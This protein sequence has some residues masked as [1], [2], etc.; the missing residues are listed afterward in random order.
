MTVE[1]EVKWIFHEEGS[2]WW[3]DIYRAGAN[4][5][6]DFRWNNSPTVSHRIETHYTAWMQ[7]M[8]QL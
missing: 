8:E 7:M 5:V 6:M 3:L 2:N 1:R 4:I